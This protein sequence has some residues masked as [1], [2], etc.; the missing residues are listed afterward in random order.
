[1]KEAQV[2][3]PVT[4]NSWPLP[5]MRVYGP[6]FLFGLTRSA[7][8][9]TVAKTEHWDIATDIQG[10]ERLNGVSYQEYVLIT[11]EDYQYVN[12]YS[13]TPEGDSTHYVNIGRRR[14]TPGVGDWEY[15]TFTD[16]VQSTMDGHNMISMGYPATAGST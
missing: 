8:A 5:M 10:S 2:T 15:L 11:H 1:M 16:Y 9:V 7:L 4:S 13:T 12:F 3:L 14:V 6:F